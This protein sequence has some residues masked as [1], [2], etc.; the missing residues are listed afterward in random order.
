MIVGYP[1]KNSAAYTECQQ[2][3]QV[4]T[5]KEA[6]SLSNSSLQSDRSCIAIDSMQDMMAAWWM[7]ELGASGAEQIDKY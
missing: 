6:Q 2:M 7:H 1:A 3:K 5:S 4:T